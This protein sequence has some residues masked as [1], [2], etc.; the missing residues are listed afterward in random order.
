MGC[1]V[2][3]LDEE[4]AVAHCRER[5]LLLADAIRHRYALAD[6]HVAYTLS[7]RSVGAA[8]E[9]FLNVARALPP[10]S[11]VLPLPA[12]RKGDPPP[13][14]T[15]SPPPA[16]A[17]FLDRTH[18][19]SHSGSHIHFR[20]SDSE[21][22]DVDDL[23]LHS[24]GAPPVYPLYADDAPVGQTYVNLNYSRNRPA[25]SSVAY[26]LQPPSS[27]TIRFG[28]VDERPPTAFPYYGYPYPPQS[29]N[30]Y[31]YPANSYTSYDGGMGGGIFG[32]SSP[33]R[34]IPPP[35]VAAGGSSTT[36]PEVPPP[37]SP[38]RTSTWDFLNPFDSYDNYCAS[39]TPSRSSKELRDE[40]GIPDL[41][42]EGHEVIKGAYGD[43]KFVPSSLA[44]ADGEYTGKAATE[45]KEG[46]IDSGG[47]DPSQKSRLV[48]AGGS[49]EHEV[50]VV[51]KN[52]VTEPADR[53]GA[54][55]FT[56]SRSYQDVSEVMQEIKTQFD[57]AFETADQVAKM[58]E[59]GKHLYHQKNSVYKA[60]ARMICGF[61]LLLTSKNEDLLVFEEEKAM[62]CGNLS[63]T[64]QKLYNWE[65]KLLEEVMAEEKI[66]VLYDRKCEYLR[67]LSERGAEAEKLEAVEI[68]IRKLSTKIRIAIQVVGTISSKINQ[69]RDEELWPQINE[70]IQ[71]YVILMW[72]VMSECHHIQCQAISEAKNLDSIVNGVKLDDIHMDAIKQLEL[73]LVDWIT[74]FSAWVTAQRS[75]VKSLNGWLVKGIHY[76]SEETDDGVPPFSPGRIGA[77]PVF[78][79]CNYWS[80]SMDMISEREVIDAMQA[81]AHDVFNIWQQRKFEQQ[82]RLMAN[83]DMD[84]KL[85]LM[86]SQEQLMLRQRKKLMLMSSEDGI[87]IPEHEVRHGSTANSLHLSLKQIFEAMENFTANSVKAYEV[88]HI[89]CEEEK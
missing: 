88:P 83:R 30:L 33:H 80:Q 24:D 20:P 53:R 32:F 40:E 9:G 14:L 41:E 11:P 16:A 18:S 61:P 35:A 59:A 8:L 26:E 72:T 21:S 1:G 51:E 37:P 25:E 86:E 7:L 52:V 54:V 87:S 17:A 85:R 45:S 60:S 84:S 43:P 67:R 47:E 13:P 12:Q 22:D 49:S 3:K 15:P 62:G 70:L 4:A 38:P 36:T 5:S 55:G 79:I 6:A 65:K 10:A 64:L 68:S 23:P 42:D 57:R 44:A 39:Y 71:G 81:F 78:I 29:A 66:R 31:S 73:D 27:E 46:V 82:Q 48:E 34:N 28:S 77:P 19:R 89:C 50:H 75:Y 2:S 74:N 56:T 63:S 58:L 76:V 69:L